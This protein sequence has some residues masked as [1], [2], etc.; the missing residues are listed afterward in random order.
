MKSKE[1]WETSHTSRVDSI[2]IVLWAQSFQLELF[3][4]SIEI[5][6][7]SLHPALKTNAITETVAL[8]A[9]RRP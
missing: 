1:P 7:S 9:S 3:K 2:A 6:L 8:P 4:S 5:H